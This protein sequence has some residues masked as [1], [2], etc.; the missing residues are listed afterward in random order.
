MNS[1]KIGSVENL[2][3]SEV[4]F[5]S[6]MRLC[7]A[8]ERRR[9][10]AEVS[11][12]TSRQTDA[13]VTNVQEVVSPV[14][15]SRTLHNDLA[16]SVGDGAAYGVMVGLGETYL[17]AFSL[18]VGLGEVYTGLLASLPM[19]LGSLLQLVSP[20]GVRQLRSHRRWVVF[21]AGLQTACFL[22][23]VAAAWHGWIDRVS[24]MLVASIYWAASLGAGPAWNTWMGS[25]VPI[26]IRAT[27]FARRS[28]LNQAMTCLGFLGGGFALQFGKNWGEQGAQRMFVALFGVSC[29]CRALSTLCLFLQSESPPE[30]KSLRDLSGKV[31]GARLFTGD[32]GRLLMF[33]V[34]MQAGVYF[35]GPYFSPYMLKLLKM[36]YWE[37]ALLLGMSFVTKFLCLP[38]WG[39]YAH[40]VGA[41]RMLWI[42]ALGIIPLAGGWLVSSNFYYLLALQAFGG[43]SWGAYELAVFLLFF[44]T[45]P[46]RERTGI[47]T[48]YNLA[49][50]AA[51]AGGSL[52]G[53]WLLDFLGVTQSA[54]LWVF[55]G[56]SILRGLTVLLLLRMPRTEVEASAMPIRPIGVQPSAGSFDS[57]ILPAMPDQQVAK[58]SATTIP[59]AP[60]TVAAAVPPAKSA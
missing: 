29:L 48:W 51:L 32:S 9:A 5:R 4:G 39:Q 14:S 12:V 25:V 57:P 52:L 53:G 24:L 17:S 56:S 36:E 42:G 26:S 2:V 18:A 19:L 30:P 45:I 55:A 37:F 40:R 38:Y 43:A 16:L 41:Q 23:L 27:F 20:W 35:A 47:L 15:E 21:C 44:E 11:G 8:A 13:V 58:A 22:P 50:S 7:R 33:A 60:L 3:F 1:G 49:N 6:R 59:V 10:R 54:Y 34:L 28:K 46:A 31:I